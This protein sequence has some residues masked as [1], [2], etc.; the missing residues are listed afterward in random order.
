MSNILYNCLK[1]YLLLSLIF[2]AFS[3]VAYRV[4]AK[5]EASDPE[6]KEFN[7]AAVIL[8]PLWPFFLIMSIS[9]FILRVLV[10]T[11]FLILFTIA[12]VAFR[13][14]FLLTWLQKVIVK[15]GNKLLLAN[16]YLIKIV[17]PQKRSK[18]IS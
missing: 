16:T 18:T 6:K 15:I 4:N 5:R 10:Q 9:L 17:I 13:K 1:G 7:P 8:A 11:I 2:V 12:L 3:A 14:P